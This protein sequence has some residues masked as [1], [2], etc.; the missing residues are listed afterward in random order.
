LVPANGELILHTE[1]AS[2]VLA[3]ENMT[4]W[5]RVVG[6]SLSYPSSFGQVPVRN[7]QQ[8]INISI[9]IN[10]MADVEWIDFR[11]QAACLFWDST[12]G[13]YSSAGVRVLSV[14]R[15]RVVCSSTH[16]TSFFVTQNISV[17]APQNISVATPQTTT[18]SAV[19]TFEMMMAAVG[20]A[21]QAA[22][23]A[24]R[25]FYPVDFTLAQSVSAIYLALRNA[26]GV[27][28][29]CNVSVP[30]FAS[31]GGVV[32]STVLEVTYT[33]DF[34]IAFRTTAASSLGNITPTVEFV[35]VSG[36]GAGYAPVKVRIDG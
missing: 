21:L 16:L 13:A 10:P 6:L 5:S 7:L 2:L 30:F 25:P 14:S 22:E 33:L 4:V 29:R 9:P 17:A 36:V 26:G 19:F 35:A 34:A 18:G 32:V 11:Y 3:A 24:G 8:T 31:P 28:T 12:T 20:N 27:Y 1:S 15:D 23:I